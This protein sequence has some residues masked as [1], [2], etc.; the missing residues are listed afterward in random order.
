MKQIAFKKSIL[1]ALIIKLLSSNNNVH[2]SSYLDDY[3][4]PTAKLALHK[5]TQSLGQPAAAVIGV[6]NELK[7]TSDHAT[8]GYSGASGYQLQNQSNGSTNL[9]NILPEKEK[10]K[11]ATFSQL[12]KAN[13]NNVEQNVDDKLSRQASKSKEEEPPNK[14]EFIKLETTG[15]SNQPAVVLN[16]PESIT[17]TTTEVSDNQREASTPETTTPVLTTSEASNSDPFAVVTAGG[18]NDQD[19]SL[20]ANNNFDTKKTI[21]NEE[22]KSEIKQVPSTETTTIQTSRSSSQQTEQQEQFNRIVE[23]DSNGSQATLATLATTTTTTSSPSS[24]K[25]ADQSQE[26]AQVVVGGYNG[27][28]EP[29]LV[30]LGENNN[31]IINNNNKPAPIISE[32]AVKETES[33]A[34]AA[35]DASITFGDLFSS[36]TDSCYDE[37]G[38]ARYCEPEFENVAYEKQVEVS[39]ECG[40]PPTRFC[41]SHNLLNQDQVKKSNCHICD[42]QNQKKKHPASYLTDSNNSANPTC[43]V[44]APINLLQTSYSNTTTTTMPSTTGATNLP[45]VW[46]IIENRPADNVSLVLN[47]DKSY[48]ITYISMQFCSLKPDSLAI[49]KSN[50][51]GA[52][53]VPYQFYSSQCQK[54]YNKETHSSTKHALVDS[55][56]SS[57]MEATCLNSS[58]TG[59]INSGRI[60]FLTH[61]GRNSNSPDKSMALQDWI[62]ATNIKIILD[63]HQASWIH[64]NLIGHHHH[65]QQ[66]QHQ[67]SIMSGVNNNK[68]QEHSELIAASSINKNIN[69]NNLTNNQDSNNS[70]EN[71][72]INPSD[73]YNY[74]ISDL[75]IGARCKCNGHADKCIHSK[76]GRLQ[77]DCRHNTAGPDCERCA[78]FHHDRPWARASQ[79]DANPCQ[80]KF[81]LS[82]PPIIT[83][84][85]F[86]FPFPLCLFIICFVSQN[87]DYF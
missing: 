65:H 45:A 68:Q 7:P 2:C 62:T 11:E 74:A 70:A 80:R 15:Q 76:E 87:Y 73:T 47:L 25:E 66:Q 59:N 5:I 26:S 27:E 55:S 78:S 77:C 18:S 38:N 48:E 57:S 41:I 37:Y 40:K 31:N 72:L 61:E 56:S 71:S 53:W 14:S 63:R 44:S 60:A 83:I 6:S 24:I 86:S 36:L 81:F 1:F 51:F 35:V 29:S 52:T 79:L 8:S 49:Y 17:T 3:F 19:S 69:K 33:N 50:D 16:Q 46:S 9:N 58:G 85:S 12:E 21:D 13:Q 42:S 67:Q 54:M 28:H 64:S 20:S 82:N 43:W 23:I 22:Q 30:A 75:T 84:F 39:S 32:E 34:V 4:L 10:E